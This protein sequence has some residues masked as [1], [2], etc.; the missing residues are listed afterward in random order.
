M[1][2]T[3][4][5]AGYSFPNRFLICL[6]FTLRNSYASKRKNAI[7]CRCF[8]FAGRYF[9]R[10]RLSSFHQTFSVEHWSR[11]IQ[12]LPRTGK[13]SNH[14]RFENENS[15]TAPLPPSADEIRRSVRR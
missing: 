2:S 9:L 12:H 11:N 15:D 3:N 1:P 7:P 4:T 13:T 10:P 8:Y 6:S 14:T 5:A